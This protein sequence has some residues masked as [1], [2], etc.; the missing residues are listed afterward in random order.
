MLW[1]TS[2]Q[3][4][5][6]LEALVPCHLQKLKSN[7]V[8]MESASAARDEIAAIAALATSLQALLYS[9]ET[10]T[11]FVSRQ[12][13]YFFF[14][15][16]ENAIRVLFFIFVS[17]T[18]P[19]QPHKCPAVI[20]AT[21]VALQLT[22]PCPG[23]S[24]QGRRLFELLSPERR[25]LKNLK[26]KRRFVFTETISTCWRRVRECRGRS[27]TSGSPERSSAGRGSPC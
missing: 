12:W 14:F 23:A 18:D 25:R 17:V 10:L 20:K 6:V 8:T 4:L 2:L 26:T 15:S 21:R 9:S 3:M 24:T 16:V 5:M 13:R 1:L 7:T 22:T 27:W 19:W 11:R